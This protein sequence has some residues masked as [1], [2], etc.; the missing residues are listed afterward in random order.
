[1]PASPKRKQNAAGRGLLA[2]KYKKTGPRQWENKNETT[3]RNQVESQAI[4]LGNDRNTLY[5]QQVQNQASNPY[6]D[7]NAALPT[8]ADLP[9]YDRNFFGGQGAEKM[10]SDYTG[11]VFRNKMANLQPQM[12]RQTE[13]FEQMAA[14]RG[15]T[16]GSEVYKEQRTLH[17]ANQNQQMQNI[18]TQAMQDSQGYMGTLGNTIN[19]GY[20]M[21]RQGVDDAAALAGNHA[22]RNIDMRNLPASDL[23][24]RQGM[25]DP[26]LSQ[27]GQYGYEGYQG[28]QNR[29]AGIKQAGIGAAGQ[30]NAA[31]AMGAAG[32]QQEQLRQ[33]GEDRRLQFRQ[34]TG[35]GANYGGY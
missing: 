26:R 32:T 4:Q 5:R 24:I 2:G 14:E 23:A 3:M 21:G 7:P 15:W 19:T 31:G 18:Q 6:T 1:M 8:R 35:Y 20:Q 28:A 9:T 13:D 25:M 22:Q 33:Q 10:M 30:V 17:D 16:P 12:A 29:Q 11:K 34:Q 27:Y